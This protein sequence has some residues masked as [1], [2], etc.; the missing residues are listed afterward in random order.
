MSFPRGENIPVHWVEMMTDGN[1]EECKEIQEEWVHCL[2]N[3]TLSGYNSR[4]SNQSFERKQS[5]TEITA[6]GHKIDIGYR[7]GL[8]LNN[9]TF[10]VDDSHLTSLSEIREWKQQ[11][12]EARNDTMVELLCDL[13]QF[14]HE[15]GLEEGE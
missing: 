13:Y 5:K 1:T 9:L 14:D 11:D 2:G 10:E 6:A 8:Y 15:P 4:L 12:I 7:N 3:L